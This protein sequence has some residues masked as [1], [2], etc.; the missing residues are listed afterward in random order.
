[1]KYIVVRAEVI[2]YYVDDMGKFQEFP[3]IFP[4]VIIHADMYRMTVHN[5]GTEGHYQYGSTNFECV[6]AGFIEM[7]SLECLGRS[8]SLGVNSRGQED[9]NLIR[10]WWRERGRV[11]ELPQ[12]TDTA[13]G[14]VDQSTRQVRDA[15]L[16]NAELR[17][18]EE[19][20]RKRAHNSI[21]ISSKRR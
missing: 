21:R 3:I 6:G 17:A 15:K 12:N 5:L 4:D 19:A 18:Q 2:P 8:D 10:N 16:Q 7:S 11:F 9:T 1:M 13:E 14:E 20:R